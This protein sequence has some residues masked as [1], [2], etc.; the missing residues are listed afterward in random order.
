MNSISIDHSIAIN[1]G[2]YF[3]VY[4]DNGAKLISQQVQENSFMS[5]ID[6]SVLARGT[7]LLVYI[8]GNEMKVAKFTKVGK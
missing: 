4:A 2:A 8:N 7:Y 3:Y 1:S 6:I 5:I